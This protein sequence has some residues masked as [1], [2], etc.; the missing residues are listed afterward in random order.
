MIA[1]FEM[2]NSKL[3][4]LQK[5]DETMFF[6]IER[7]FSPRDVNILSYIQTLSKGSL[8]RALSLSYWQYSNSIKPDF[9]KY[10][11]RAQKCLGY[12]KIH[13]LFQSNYIFSVL[14]FGMKMVSYTC[15]CRVLGVCDG[16]LCA[17]A[18]GVFS[19][20]VQVWAKCNKIGFVVLV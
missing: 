11:K 15:C 13:F 9:S 18:L 8:D 2:G 7:Q 1:L 6:S 14:C 17:E 16:V 4:F 10:V 20:W 12:I 5:C 19:L 3:L